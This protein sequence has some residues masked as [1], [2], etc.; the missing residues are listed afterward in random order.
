MTAATTRLRD[1]VQHAYLNAR[2]DAWNEG[3][4]YHSPIPSEHVVEAIERHG[5]LV[6]D[7]FVEG[8]V[9]TAYQQANYVW[10]SDWVWEDRDVADRIVHGLMQMDARGA[11]DWRLLSVAA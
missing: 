6:D 10:G 4:G 2:S 5:I 11:L 9:E 8:I 3:P 1:D 7:G